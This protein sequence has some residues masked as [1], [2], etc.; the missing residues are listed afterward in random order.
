MNLCRFYGFLV[1]GAVLSKRE[2][3]LLVRDSLGEDAAATVD[4]AL[5]GYTGTAQALLFTESELRSTR[6]ELTDR[7]NKYLCGRETYCVKDSG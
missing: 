2:A 6:A 7:I 1:T 5:Q 4:K 3:G